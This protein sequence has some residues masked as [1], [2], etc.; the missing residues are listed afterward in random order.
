MSDFVLVA[1][2]CF[3]LQFGALRVLQR[4][5]EPIGTVL[6][7]AVWGA[8]AAGA[9]LLLAR[10]RGVRHR[11][12]RTPWPAA[13]LVA[14]TAV[15]AVAVYPGV[16]GRRSTG[17]GSDADDAV[18]LVVDRVRDGVD[19][20]AADTYLGNPP[21]TGPGSVLWALPFPGRRAY[22]AAVVVALA[23]TLLAL[24]RWSG[25]WRL[26]SLT[27]LL[28]GAS[29][30][31]W[32][33]VAQGSDHLAMAGGL[34]VLVTGVRQAT[35]TRH[36]AHTSRW[37]WV[38]WAVLAGVLATWRAA[39]LHLPVL[40]AVALWPRSRRAAGL[41][42]GV[43]LAVALGLHAAL[44]SRTAGWDAYDPVQQLLVK[45]DEDLTA[46]GRALVGAGVAAAGLVVVAEA[47]RAA[48]RPEVLVL[49]GIGGPLAAIAVAGLLGADDAAA[50]SE[51]SYLLP[52]LVL[53]AVLTARGVLESPAP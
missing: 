47:R 40:L 5:P 31:W 50:W 44:L 14:L 17:G 1:L 11:A 29:V 19:P 6:L 21:T 35:C 7:V 39:Y 51:A 15:F 27:A 12:L 34:A 49:A 2:L 25:S 53:A 45:S 30:P 26:P 10:R 43:G 20:F 36:L 18:V 37:V 52:T 24:R 3:Q 13:L 48:P 28:V 38:G 8:T 42:A 4:L 33:A 23:G 32:E 46:A 22:A 9:W 16:D 41:V